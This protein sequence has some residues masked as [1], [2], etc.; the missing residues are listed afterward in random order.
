[1]IPKTITILSHLFEVEEVFPFQINE[2][3]NNPAQLNEVHSIR[4]EF[5]DITQK[6]ICIDKTLP[7]DLK[8]Y[9][10]F[11]AIW[12]ILLSL[13]DQYYNHEGFSGFSHLLFATLKDNRLGYLFKEEL[14][15]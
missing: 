1:M 14:N 7:E 15:G 10:L 12:E 11:H 4:M 3:Y 9:S 2:K 13:C 5:F 8:E 6:K